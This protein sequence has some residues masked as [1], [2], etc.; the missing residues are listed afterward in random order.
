MQLTCS[1]DFSYPALHSGVHASPYLILPLPGTV[2]GVQVPLR[3]LAG[4]TYTSTHLWLLA[5]ATLAPHRRRATA[6]CLAHGEPPRNMRVDFWPPPFPRSRRRARARATAVPGGRL[7]SPAM[8]RS[9]ER[10]TRSCAD[11]ATIDVSPCR[12]S[13]RWSFLVK[14]RLRSAVTNAASDKQDRK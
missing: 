9:R 8:V 10:A 1:V 7:T 13:G 3:P 5:C 2:G 12:T 11:L 6:K 14:R 4:V